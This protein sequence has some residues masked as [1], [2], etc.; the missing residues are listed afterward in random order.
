MA[1]P[2]I[3]APAT[4]A[5]AFD[6]PSDRGWKAYAFPIVIATGGTVLA[7]AGTMYFTRIRRVPAGSISN[8]HI[9]VAVAGATLTAGQC[10][11]ALFTA[12]GTRVG[13][14]G[15]QAAAWASTGLKNMALDAPYNNQTV[16]DL[17]AAFW[18]N[19][20][21]GPNV[22]RGST[23]FSSLVPN[24]G[25]SAPNFVAGSADTGLT[26]SAPASMG[27]QTPLSFHYWAALS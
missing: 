7:T 23:S 8:I 6:Q 22:Y 21:T 18:F 11:A 3:S 5:Y 26:A 24:L 16:A 9:Y 15:D 12:G 19:G 4:T 17:Y 1:P 2:R 20:T 27:S 25:L 14:T 10:F 13:V